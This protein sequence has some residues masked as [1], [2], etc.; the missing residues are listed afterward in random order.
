M[1]PFPYILLAG[2]LAVRAGSAFINAGDLAPE[3]PA[4]ETVLPDTPLALAPAP[5]AARV[6]H[7]AE[8]EKIPAR[9]RVEAP[10]REICIQRPVAPPDPARLLAAMQAVLLEARI[11]IL[12]FS[13]RPAPEGEIEFSRGGLHEGP[14]GCFWSGN[15]RYAGNHLFP[16]WAR[17]A[18][19]VKFPR[20]IAA[21]DLA[22]GREITPDLVR[23]ETRDVFPLAAGFPQS[24]SQV[25]GRSPRLFIRG[26]S[27]IRADQ[28]EAAKE[29]R[30]GETV[31][32]DVWNGAAHLKLEAR[33]EASG[34]L[35]QTI[36]V[37]NPETQKRFLARVEG[38]KRVSVGGSAA[39]AFKEE[40]DQ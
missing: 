16:I 26:A 14:A 11:E 25:V 4:L 39:A 24:A 5:G 19:S 9:L 20:V 2:C 30:T 21:V 3:F 10:G 37:R 13:R 18:V 23:E 36:P 28:L 8:L 34:V 17:V 12:D 38:K 40:E 15:V 35:G 6:L 33:A 7:L 29:V 32:V 31:R 27:V 1:I 22:P